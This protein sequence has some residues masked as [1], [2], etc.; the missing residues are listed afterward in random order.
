MH[1]LGARPLDWSQLTAGVSV[2]AGHQQSCDRE[3][4]GK[5]VSSVLLINFPEFLVLLSMRALCSV[6]ILL[7]V[8]MFSE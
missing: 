8:K 2:R 3:G 7:I 6:H 5:A 1:V 4:A